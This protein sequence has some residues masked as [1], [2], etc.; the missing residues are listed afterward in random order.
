MEERY[1]GWLFHVEHGAKG[2]KNISLEEKANLFKDGWVDW[3]D[4]DKVSP[5]ILPNSKPDI[6]ESKT[7]YNP[8]PGPSLE[9]DPAQGWKPEEKPTE[10]WI[11]TITKRLPGRPKKVKP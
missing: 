10:P 9:I 8:D 6:L 1:T 11:E 2:F 7:V 5:T 4:R 3:H